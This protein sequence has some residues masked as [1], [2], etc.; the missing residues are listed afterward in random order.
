MKFKREEI[1][2]VLQESENEQ[3]VQSG[4]AEEMKVYQNNEVIKEGETVYI[5]MDMLRP[6]GKNM[7]NISQIE[8]LSDLIRLSGGILQ[9]IIV[10]PADP[11]G[12]YTITTGERR[13]RAAKLLKEQGLYPEKFD[14]KV[15]CMIRGLDDIDLPLSQ[16][17]KEKF[18]ILTTNQ[19][20]DKSDGEKMMEM[21]EW[22]N[23][24][25]ALRAAGAEYLPLHL[26]DG[27]QV[28]I[29]G[30]PTRELL[31]GQ[32][33]ISTGQ[34]S[35]ME[36]VEKKGS[37]QLINMLLNDSL[38]LSAAEEIIRVDEQKQNAVLRQLK[39][40]QKNPDSK[41][42]KIEVKKQVEKKL[43]K[44]YL[45]RETVSRELE[46]IVSSM[47]DT[48]TLSESEYKTYQK[49]IKQMKKILL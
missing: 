5:D 21:Q 25:A 4:L 42:T 23:I 24:I 16:E 43:E 29:K 2:P 3:R 47:K 8:K 12:Y 32:L 44:I 7:Y 36:N 49:W 10:L 37:S 38:D 9:N 46:V 34:V 27:E 14:G 48:I 39:K 40:K 18:A 28:K 19:Y 45:E 30:I 6:N 20:R 1:E 26:T 17:M 22:R 33:G 31:A 41:I 13:W 11:D 35:R 15:P